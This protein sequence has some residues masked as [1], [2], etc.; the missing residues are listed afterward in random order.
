MTH[1]TGGPRP[2]LQRDVQRLLGRCL[3]RIQ[4]YERLLKAMLTHHELAGSLESLAAEQARR[5]DKFADMTLGT[6][7]KLLFESLVVPEGY[8]RNPVPEGKVPTDR[9]S[10]S[11]SS[12]MEMSEQ[13]RAQA[14]A[15]IKELVDLRN[16]LVHHLLEMF[17][18][19]SE[20]GCVQA[21]RHL[22]ES[23]DRIDRHF[24][25]L[26]QW[27]KNMDEARKAAAQFTQSPEFIDLL[28]NGIAPDGSFEWSNAGIVRVLRDAL[29]NLSSGEWLRLDKAR[30]WIALTNPE[31]KP[32]KYGCKTWPQVLSESRQFDLHYRADASGVKVGWFRERG[33]NA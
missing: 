9:V 21:V 17:D 12:R 5:A 11:I 8:E 28:V 22:E 29:K 18:V 14:Q 10:M 25:E 6:L 32:Q 1:A 19:W 16:Q 33:K 26:A 3:L 23:F 24:L 15:A 13:A 4:Q 31:Q 30:D 20:E 2:E 27:A 7:A